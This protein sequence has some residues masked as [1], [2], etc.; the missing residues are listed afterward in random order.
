MD[1]GNSQNNGNDPPHASTK[2]LNPQH[3]CILTPDSSLVQ[4]VFFF[5]LLS[6]R[7]KAKTASSGQVHRLS[8]STLNSTDLNIIYSTF[9]LNI[10]RFLCSL[11]DSLRRRTAHRDI[12]I[13]CTAV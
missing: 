6:R 1:S 2:Y 7:K 9:P 3:G 11:L 5:F 12:N 4:T 10:Y 13:L 8:S